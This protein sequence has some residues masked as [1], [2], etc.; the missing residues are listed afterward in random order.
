M[1]DNNMVFHIGTA[2]GSM[3]RACNHVSAI[4]NMSGCTNVLKSCSV[5]IGCHVCHGGLISVF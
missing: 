4:R 2:Q 3:F 1:H 5:D